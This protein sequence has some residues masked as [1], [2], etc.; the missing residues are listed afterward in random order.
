[1]I[2]RNQ[3]ADFYRRVKQTE[4]LSENEQFDDGFRTKAREILAAIRCCPDAYKETLVLR[5]VEGMT[6]PEIAER[7]GLTPERFG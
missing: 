1:M 5:L 3:A 2:A 6:G 7:T 4:E